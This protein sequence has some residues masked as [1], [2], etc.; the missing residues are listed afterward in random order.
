MH[1]RLFLTTT[2]AALGFAGAAR[3]ESFEVTLSDDEW[4]E[5]PINHPSDVSLSNSTA[6]AWTR[7]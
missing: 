2:L 6:R 4:K 3:A 5:R 1:R 7:L